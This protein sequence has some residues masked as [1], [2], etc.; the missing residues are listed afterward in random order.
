M[1]APSGRSR[2]MGLGCVSL[3][4]VA[5]MRT[6]LSQAPSQPAETPRPQQQQ[7]S[8]EF[9]PP[10]APSLLIPAVTN[11]DI[12]VPEVAFETSRLGSSI[13]DE[14]HDVPFAITES[15]LAAVASAVQ[16]AA[17][18]AAAAALTAATCSQVPVPAPEQP[19]PLSLGTVRKRRRK[20]PTGTG[21]P[22]PPPP[23]PAPAGPQSEAPR[24]RAFL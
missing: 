7:L 24:A 1:A 12:V 4:L 23:P 3:V 6:V 16:A 18:A 13:R 19:Q 11:V 5:V 10:E 8:L 20:K 22:P 21:P 17:A 14:L 2:L 15:D 9:P